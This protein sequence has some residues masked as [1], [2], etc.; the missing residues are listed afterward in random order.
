MWT[1]QTPSVDIA[2]LANGPSSKATANHDGDES[3]VGLGIVT[4]LFP[5]ATR[6]GD[7]KGQSGVVPMFTLSLRWLLQL[8]EMVVE[9][10]VSPS[11]VVALLSRSPTLDELVEGLGLL[12]TTVRT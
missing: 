11:F 4:P 2:Q 5:S 12:A 7:Q 8:T 1:D 9:G 6:L 3:R 10:R